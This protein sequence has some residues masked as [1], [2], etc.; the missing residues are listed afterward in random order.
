MAHNR[1]VAMVEHPNAKLAKTAWSATSA[2]DVGALSRVCTPD[3]VWHASGRGW[4]AGDYRGREAVFEYLASLG[5]SADRFD[6]RF[7]HVLVG[8][9]RAAVLFHATGRRGKQTL[10]NDYVLLFRI[11]EGL[12]AEV[13]SIAW[14][15]Q[16][17]DDFWAEGRAS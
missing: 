6:S 1:V 12:I 11:E 16:A 3:V 7:D 10:D 5:E 15:Q 17:D 13:W 2:G 4:R 14:D 8:D 9:D